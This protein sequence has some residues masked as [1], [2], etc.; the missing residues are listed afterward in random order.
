MN[1]QKYIIKMNIIKA[2]IVIQSETLNNI[3]KQQ[4]PTQK[5]DKTPVR[6]QSR[7]LE[8]NFRLMA[9]F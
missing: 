8:M 6:E 3:Q 7:K 9:C 4:N 5:K 2:N 1:E